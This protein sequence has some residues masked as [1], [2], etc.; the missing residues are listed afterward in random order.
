MTLR[1]SL[2]QLDYTVGDFDGN[3]QLMAQ[4]V[5]AAGPADLIVFSELSLSGYYPA[6]KLD[7]PAF[8]A[9]QARALEQLAAVSRQTPA[10]L[11]FGMATPNQGPGKP[12][13]NSLV[14]LQ[15]GREVLRY[16]KQLLPDYDVFNEQRHFEPGPRQPA[17]L[18][19]AGVKV[20]F[21]VCEDAWHD[22]T[23]LYEQDPAQ[24]LR[25]AGAQLVVSINASPSCVG[26]QAQ[27]DALFTALSRRL[28][29][30][31]VFVNQVGGNDSLVFDG[32]SFVADPAVGVVARLPWFEPA[33]ESLAFEP[34][35][36]F[37]RKAGVLDSP[38][39]LPELNDS[40]FY[41]QQILL[42]LRGYLRKIGV[43]SVVVGC[44][45][46][47]DS[48][49]TLALARDALGAE[50]VQAVTMPS[51]VST[52]G[53]VSDSVDLC[54]NLG[55]ALH[56]FP[57]APLVE[58]YGTGF[59]AAFASELAGL[60]L[61]NL[62]SRVRGTILMAF[63]NRHGPLLLTTG[64]K[65]EVAV[66]YCTLYGDTNGGLNLIGDLYK[67]EVFELSREF[68]RIHGAEIIP[69]AIITKEPSAELAEGQRDS[70]SL[71]PY[72]VLDEILKWH[73]EGEALRPQ[74]LAAATDFVERL[75]QE[76]GGAETVARVQQL[77]ARA[78]F[79]RRQ[80]PPILKLRGR[81]FGA[82]WQMPVAAR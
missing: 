16:H 71:P 55:I 78:E 43:R 30:P 21:L 42:G 64:N 6:D 49:L 37:S 29:L 7:L 56:E 17:V 13:F 26:K 47:I 23:S 59:Q 73:I 66:G 81:A 22:A 5:A 50:N 54:R 20:G 74:E 24:D 27:R 15:A 36:G 25:D 67:T 14:V 4:A 62:Q 53:S 19:L 18:E 32:A 38:V 44:S 63:S 68:N 45:G 48:A 57:I 34:G 35:R 11:A 77:V 79:K 41:Y 75:M 76:A 80:A 82:G 46:G 51:R 31:L 12:W 69:E 2:V 40:R 60:S 70:D 65:S 61:E 39:A 3:A 33:Q 1:L 58:A 10:A 72:P 8:R 9:G 52:A 28:Q